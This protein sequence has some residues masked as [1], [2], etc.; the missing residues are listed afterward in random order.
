MTSRPPHTLVTQNN[1]T[2]CHFGHLGV[3]PSSHVKTSFGCNKFPKLLA[4]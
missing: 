1:E 3:E 2:A 4:T